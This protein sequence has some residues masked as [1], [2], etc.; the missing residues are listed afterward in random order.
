MNRVKPGSAAWKARAENMLNAEACC[1]LRWCY[2]SFAD[3]SG[4]LGGVYVFARGILSAVAATH[5]M[6]INP[7]GQ[8]MYM[9]PED[10]PPPELINRLLSREELEKHFSPLERVHESSNYSTRI[11]D[12]SSATRTTECL[13]QGSR[14]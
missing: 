13:I 4:F 3:E 7:G 8:V 5:E 2:M 1:P 14:R 10:A 11:V 12:N 9:E 6:G